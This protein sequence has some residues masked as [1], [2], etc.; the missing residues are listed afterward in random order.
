MTS[1]DLPAAIGAGPD[2]TLHIYYLKGRVAPQADLSAPGFIGNWEEDG[3]SFL[4]YNRSCRPKIDRLLAAQPHLEMID[5]Y[6]M[7][8]AEWLGE[9]PAAYRA[10][11]LEVVPV[12]EAERKDGRPAPDRHRLILDPGVVFGSGTHATT[13]DCLL[14]LSAVYGEGRPRTVIDLGTGTGILALAAAALGCRSALAVDLNLLAVRTAAGNIRINRREDRVLA[15]QGRAEAFI[16]HPAEL[17]VANIHHDVMR[18][19]IPSA[20]FR[21]KKWFILSGLMRS[22]AA[23]VAD[24]LAGAGSIVRGHS[25]GA[26]IWHTY[27]GI[28]P[29]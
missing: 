24:Q 11:R 5:A 19:L 25:I 16:D 28:N 9:R 4:F 1:R 27:W 26:D 14:A 12:W 10:G 17:L 2:Q 7:T 15:V 21:Q 8:Y 13:R 3:F 23:A 29:P 20:G 6:R 18:R 22:Q